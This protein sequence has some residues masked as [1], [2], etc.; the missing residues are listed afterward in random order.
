MTNDVWLSRDYAVRMSRK[1]HE[2]L[3][4]EA[5]LA[6]SLPPEIGY[7]KVIAHGTTFGSN[8]LILARRPGTV[9][10]RIWPELTKPQ[11]RRAISQLAARL[12]ILHRVV[13][14]SDLQAPSGAPQLLDADRRPPAAPLLTALDRLLARPHVDRGLIDDAIDFVRRTADTLDPFPATTLIHGDLTFENLLCDGIDLTAMLD[15]EW[16]RG[17]PP[18][19]DLDVLLRFCALPH[20]H[21]ADD[22]AHRA[23]AEDYAAVPD[24]LAEDYPALFAH[25]RLVA[26]LKLYAVAYD[27]RDLV[28][29]PPIRPVADLPPNHAYH[30]LSRTL[31]GRSHLERLALLAGGGRPEP[32]ARSGEIQ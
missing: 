31:N 1:P 30:R 20:L 4:R 21:V 6:R 15:F 26:R 29:H 23:H 14:P 3:S 28:E 9:L 13:C 16:A 10:A 17:G 18:D 11:R 27:V 8:W 12:R 25:R 22:Y 2:R 7:P 24:W 19:L 32:T 5:E